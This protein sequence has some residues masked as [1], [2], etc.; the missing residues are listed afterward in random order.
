VTCILSASADEPASANPIDFCTGSKTVSKPH[1]KLGKFKDVPR[2]DVAL[3]K[4]HIC[5]PEVRNYS[6]WGA[7]A[8]YWRKYLQH[9]WDLA[10]RALCFLAPLVTPLG[11]THIDNCYSFVAKLL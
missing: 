2:L 10:H 4:K 9:C 1:F 11:K 6:L 5:R 7:N 8:L 3:C